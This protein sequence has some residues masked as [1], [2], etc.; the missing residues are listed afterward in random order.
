[1][2]II[3]MLCCCLWSHLL[4]AQ[5]LT[6]VQQTMQERFESMSPERQ[7]VLKKRFAAFKQL[8]DGMQQLMLRA[9]KRLRSLKPADR[10]VILRF[11]GRHFL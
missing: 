6:S 3:M 7:A 11:L 5:D 9:A 8:D 1:M 2:K 4:T 10:K